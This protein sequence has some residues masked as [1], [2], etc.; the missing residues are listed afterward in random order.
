MLEYRI[1]PL[2]IA[3]CRFARYDVITGAALQSE[4]A[5]TNSGGFSPADFGDSALI[6]ESRRSLQFLYNPKTR[7]GLADLMKALLGQL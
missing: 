1:P 3:S 5:E 7:P 4:P 6:E 2:I